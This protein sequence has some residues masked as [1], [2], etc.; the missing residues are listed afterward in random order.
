V[1]GFLWLILNNF[2]TKPG[3]NLFQGRVEVETVYGQLPGAIVLL[4]QD[5]KKLAGA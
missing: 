3:L 5:R 1:E 4:V 2:K